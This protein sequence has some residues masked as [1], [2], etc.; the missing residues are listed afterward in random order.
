MGPVSI[1]KT[2]K[3]SSLLAPVLF[4]N[5]GLLYVK[6]IVGMLTADIMQK[7]KERYDA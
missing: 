4:L 1:F 7:G 6:Q 2:D 5:V 3:H